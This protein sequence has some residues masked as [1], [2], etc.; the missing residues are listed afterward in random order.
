MLASKGA[1]VNLR[2]PDRDLD[3]A[4]SESPLE[5][6]ANYYLGLLAAFK[7]GADI[8]GGRKADARQ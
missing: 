2:I 3:V 4:A 1:D 8:A 6:C 7:G 5:L